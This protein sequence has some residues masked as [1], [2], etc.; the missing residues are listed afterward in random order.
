MKACKTSI[1]FICHVTNES[2]KNSHHA[3]RGCVPSFGS[4][5]EEPVVHDELGS[6]DETGAA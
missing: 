5:A 2:Q 1:E 4:A 3:D 6:R